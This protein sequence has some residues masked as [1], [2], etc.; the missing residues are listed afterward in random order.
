MA[1]VP[2]GKDTASLGDF[3]QILRLRL[4]LIILILSLVV[5]TALAVTAFMPRWY[6]ATTKVRV[7]K[8]EGEVKLFQAQSSNNY[9]PYFL[10]DQFKIMQSEKILYPV[11]ERLG[12]NGKLAPLLGSNTPLPPSI[13]YRYLVDK[14]L[15]IESQRSSS[16]IEI[17]VFAQD[18]QLAADVANE[19]AR[20][21]SSDRI[22][23]ATSDQSEGL[24]HLRQ[25]LGK[26][27]EVVRR[28]RDAVEKLRKDLDIS[29]VD[30]N[31]RYSDM[32]IERLRQMQNTL[33]AL[34]VDAIGRKTRWER[35]KSIP[36]EDRISLVNSEL[37]PDQNI[38]NLLQAYLMA[39]Q[40]VTQLKS[41]LGEAHP[42][43]I[44][45]IEARAKIKEQL[46]VQLKGY[47]SSL[48]IAYKEA[49]ARV[50]ELKSQLAQAKVEQILSARERMRP[51]EEAAQKL[52]DE[53]R[54]LTT[55]KLT[56]RQREID[57][58]VPKKTI[59]ILNTAEPA[60]F[61]SKPNLLLNATF[62]FLFGGIF[63]VGVAVLL[64]YFDTSFRNVA[65][66]ETR[67]RLPVLGVI[68][69]TRDPLGSSSDDPAEVEPYRVLHTNLNLTLNAKAPHALVIFSAGPGEGKSTTLHRL[70]RLMGAGG[71]RVIL[72]DSDLRRPTQHRLADR[73]KEPGLSELLL[74]HRTLD[75]VVQKNVS[76][77]LDFIPSGA[78]AG[79]TLS[80]IY[81]NRLREIITELKQRYEK[82]VFD[83]PPIIGVSDASV[84]VSAVDGAVLLIQHR[85]NP[86]SMVFRAQQIV[87]GLKTKLI[88]V[89]LNQVPANA[90]GD[91]GY[92]THNY[93]Y[94]SDA[95]GAKAR[96]R[97]ERDRAAGHLPG[98]RD[99]KDRLVLREP[100]QK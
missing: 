19:I 21:Y 10:Q 47:E 3:L 75:E 93:A 13:T 92:Y 48:E 1:N 54:L 95:S 39:D 24:A 14:M 61:P 56:L 72:I 83:S 18:P 55:L 29:G 88:G 49:D 8:P 66:V 35:F 96:R 30:L 58:Q 97:T 53:Q 25:E 37:I 32:E 64:E 28:Q 41:R 79:F 9:D 16:L 77:G 65:D 27:E 82:I 89:V 86:Q 33:I 67:L 12:L 26:Q 5:V 23:L 91:Y 50:A 59:E 84:L 87:E 38:Q 42:D 11:I 40:K 68:P 4:G 63:A 99:E 78:G 31:A 94:Y 62:A 57:F 51:F 46:D 76:P 20:T 34:S 80:L 71:E 6:L 81:G 69:F 70:A 100:D 90:G 45:A 36:P 60:K 2:A 15:R 85:R 43:L 98:G 22:A 74:G 17:N 44:S 7:E 52:D 73:P